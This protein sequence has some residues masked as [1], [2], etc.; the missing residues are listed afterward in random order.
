MKVFP[1]TRGSSAGLKVFTQCPGTSKRPRKPWVW[2]SLSHDIIH[3]GG[4]AWG[5][6]PTTAYLPG[7]LLC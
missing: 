6:A 1:L 2:Q 3:A 4:S 7:N 5:N